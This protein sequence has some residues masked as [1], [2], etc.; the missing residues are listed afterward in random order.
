MSEVELTDAEQSIKEQFREEVGY[1]HPAFDEVLKEDPTFFDRYREWYRFPYD[2]DA[3]DPKVTEFIL[4]AAYSQTTHL[5]SQGIRRHIGRAFDAGATFEEILEVLQI[6]TVLSV[7]SYMTGAKILD[8]QLDISARTDDDVI[9][10]FLDTFEE[11]RHYRPEW[12]GPYIAPDPSYFEAYVD[13]SG[14]VWEDGVLDPKVREF[15]YIA[16]DATPAH[17]LEEGI[18]GHME[19]AIEYGATQE[20]LVQVFELVSLLS[21]DTLSVGLPILVDEARNR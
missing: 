19:N 11:K 1:W 6:A 13:F 14:H 17:L 4:I 10:E 15:I 8:E 9:E 12:W 21:L 20:E 5:R 7:H 2:S 16:I 3:L 18:D